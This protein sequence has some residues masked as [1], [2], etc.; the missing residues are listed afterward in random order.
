[1]NNVIVKV[2]KKN[3]IDL[4]EKELNLF[5]NTYIESYDIDIQYFP[6]SNSFSAVLIARRKY[7]NG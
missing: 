1:M 6:M 5:Y 2:I 7:S 4:F 3:D